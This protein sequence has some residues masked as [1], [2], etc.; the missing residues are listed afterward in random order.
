[1]DGGESTGF[2]AEL[3]RLRRA[4]GLTQA[5]LGE[6]AGV[7]AKCITRYECGRRRP[8]GLVWFARMVTALAASDRE[9]ADLVRAMAEGEDGD[10]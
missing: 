5:R 9:I 7:P 3:R 6:R 1:M 10:R 2:P 8:T 4:R